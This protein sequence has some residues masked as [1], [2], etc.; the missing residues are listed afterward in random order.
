MF[1]LSE[2]SPLG[3]EPRYSWGNGGSSAYVSGL[4]AKKLRYRSPMVDL[5]LVPRPILLTRQD[6]RSPKA[7]LTA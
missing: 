5:T 7:G 6:L 4:Q 3:W 2:P 1:Q